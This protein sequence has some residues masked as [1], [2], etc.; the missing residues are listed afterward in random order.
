MR[1]RKARRRTCLCC[2]KKADDA[3]TV[4]AIELLKLHDAQAHSISNK[5]EKFRRLEL[6]ISGDAVEDVRVVHLSKRI[7]HNTPAGF[8][9]DSSSHLLECLS[10]EVYGV[11]FSTYGREI[12][13]QT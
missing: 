8:N 9:N 1:R 4:L 11:L 2:A 7:V 3:D 13:L 10:S 5:P 6:A 12:T